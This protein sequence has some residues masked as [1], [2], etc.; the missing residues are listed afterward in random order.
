MKP[1]VEKQLRVLESK[2]SDVMVEVVKL[3]E[4]VYT[5][6][7]M[8]ESCID[9]QVTLTEYLANAISG[10]EQTGRALSWIEDYGEYDENGSPI[11]FLTEDAKNALIESH[12][13]A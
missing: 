7:L 3:G 5:S 2:I 4:L 12:E 6:G 13:E 10:L 9:D 8:A 11:E 1:E